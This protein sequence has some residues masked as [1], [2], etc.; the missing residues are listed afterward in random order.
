MA[1]MPLR[2]KRALSHKSPIFGLGNCAAPGRLARAPLH[3][4]TSAPLSR[5]AFMRMLKNPAASV[6]I[7]AFSS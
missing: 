5:I 6:T 1:K 7:A 4:V 2:T 3:S